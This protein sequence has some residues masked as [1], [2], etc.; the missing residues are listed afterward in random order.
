M[1]INNLVRQNQLANERLKQRVSNQLDSTLKQQLVLMSKPLVWAIQAKM[2]DGNMDDVDRYLK[3]L[4]KE[5]NFEEIAIVNPK[6]SIIAST[7]QRETGHPYSIF[8]NKTFLN[9]D[10]TQVNIQRGRNLIITSPISETNKN[11]GVL[12]FKYILP[13]YK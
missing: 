1:E 9:V 13:A 10:H 4:V 11:L 5:K 7:D 8:Y 2:V 6:G 3:Q 12:S